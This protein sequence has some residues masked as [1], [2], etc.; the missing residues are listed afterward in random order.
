MYI[1]NFG[2]GISHL[3]NDLSNSI[4]SIYFSDFLSHFLWRPFCTYKPSRYTRMI[5]WYIKAVPTNEELYL[6]RI[7][8]RNSCPDPRMLPT[9]EFQFLDISQRSLPF[10]L[11][12]ILGFLN[13]DPF[14]QRIRGAL[15]FSFLCDPGRGLAMSLPPRRFLYFISRAGVTGHFMTAFVALLFQWKKR[16][17]TEEK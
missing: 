8:P 14:Y 16:S 12:Y 17:E 10:F 4:P 13:Q 7:F 5:L 6:A 9:W 3:E 11:V 15:D 2:R 1:A